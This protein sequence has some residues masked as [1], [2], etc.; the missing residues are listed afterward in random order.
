LNCLFCEQISISVAHLIST[1]LSPF[2]FCRFYN[3]EKPAENRLISSIALFHSS[4]EQI[5]RA[6]CFVGLSVTFRCGE[7]VLNGNQISSEANP[8]GQAK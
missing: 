6:A 2:N 5:W 8:E 4:V 1:S 7:S 3:D